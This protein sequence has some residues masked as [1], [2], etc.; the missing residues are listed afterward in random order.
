MISTI[1]ILCYYVRFTYKKNCSCEPQYLTSLGTL[2]PGAGE[3][4][5]H[6]F[7]ASAVVSTLCIIYR[8]VLDTVA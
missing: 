7:R 5:Q 8:R 1:Q 2:F 6:V 4:G 3:Q